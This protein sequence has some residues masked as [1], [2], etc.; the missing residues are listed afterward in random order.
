MREEFRNQWLD[1]KF[2][3]RFSINQ[4]GRIKAWLGDKQ[5][6][7]YRGV[8]AYPENEQTGYTRR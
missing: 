6:N 2:Q 1:F 4:N 7:D 8:N 5:V 3:I